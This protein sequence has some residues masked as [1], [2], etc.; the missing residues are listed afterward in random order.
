MF[1][2]V[3]DDMGFANLPNVRRDEHDLR[4]V[5]A[6]ANREIDGL[7]EPVPRQVEVPSQRVARPA[8][9]AGEI[10]HWKLFRKDQ[11]ERSSNVRFGWKADIGNVSSALCL[12]FADQLERIV[13]PATKFE[14]LL[15][16]AHPVI[17]CADIH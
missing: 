11:L 3:H 13:A 9:Q 2:D 14:L 5:A 17:C 7:K 8:S 15:R 16:A 4:A 6:R 10:L 1:T 12:G